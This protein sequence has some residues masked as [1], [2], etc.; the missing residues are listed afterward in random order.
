[1]NPHVSSRSAVFLAESWRGF[2][3]IG[4]QKKRGHD[5]RSRFAELCRLHKT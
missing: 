2:G 1:M 5:H 3:L 4:S